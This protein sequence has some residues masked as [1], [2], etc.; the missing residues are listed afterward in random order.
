MKQNT[1]G[2]DVL[3]FYM[4]TEEF[5]ENAT[6]FGYPI[7][8]RLRGTIDILSKHEH[9]DS[10]KQD[11]IPFT[12]YRTVGQMHS[13]MLK[14]VH[15]GAF[16]R[17]TNDEDSSPVYIEGGNAIDVLGRLRYNELRSDPYFRDIIEELEHFYDIYERYFRYVNADLRAEIVSSHDVYVTSRRARGVVA[18]ALKDKDAT[19]ELP[20]DLLWVPH[21]L[22]RVL[23]LITKNELKWHN[24]L[25]KHTILQPDTYITV[26]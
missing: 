4:D 6:T 26:N 7:S 5:K 12:P 10:Q 19:Q 25:S 13:F 21:T 16:P 14:D 8:P 2:S 23:Y 22:Y 11:D 3:L 1:I 17:R 18:K 15:R 24:T 20:T 9:R